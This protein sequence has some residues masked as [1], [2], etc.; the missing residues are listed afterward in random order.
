[1]R[2][3]IIKKSFS[4]K[5]PAC[6]LLIFLIFCFP[7]FY[8]ADIKI[9]QYTNENT[10]NNQEANLE[11]TSYK[12]ESY[13]SLEYKLST[14]TVLLKTRSLTSTVIANLPSGE[15]INLMARYDETIKL[16]RDNNEIG[17]IDKNIIS[18][19]ASSK[20]PFYESTFVPTD[21]IHN[22][23]F[24]NFDYE[25]TQE[26]L[27]NLRNLF[28]HGTFWN[29]YNIDTSG[30]SQDWTSSITTSISCSHDISGLEFCNEYIG[31][32]NEEVSEKYLTK[33]FEFASMISDSIF[34]KSA[35]FYKHSN[36]S[37]IEIGDHIIDK[38]FFHS[39]IVTEKTDTYIKVLDCD[40]DKKSC[41]ISWD[42]EIATENFNSGD[43][44][45]LNRKIQ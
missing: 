24:Y 23:L 20:L 38:N 33:S 26:K 8:S 17:F 12:P 36:F 16:K 3:R 9:T 40:G 22:V 28:K 42:R 21:T 10:N 30:L 14:S 2:K 25:N 13:S 45:V 4:Q 27:D 15:V 44:L 1:M 18:A 31:R 32:S 11:Q 7:L 39:M 5:L 29:H 34:G 19:D 37:E 43:F 41:K 6:I 35:Y